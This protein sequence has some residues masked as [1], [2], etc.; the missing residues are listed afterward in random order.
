LIINGASVVFEGTTANDFETTLTVTDP[1]ADRTITFPNSSGTVALSGSISLGTDT[2]GNYV[3]DVSAGT[4]V[5]VSHTP[6]EGSTPTI[7]IGQAV[8]TIANVQFYSVQTTGDITVG[9]NLTVNGT[10]TTLNTSTLQ[11][12]DNVVT[13]NHGAISPINNAGIE[14]NRGMAY[15][16][17]AIRWNEMSDRWEFTNDGTNYTAIGGSIM[18]S[19]TSAAIITMDIGA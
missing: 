15:F 16:V 18:S 12:E 17:P 9:G 19:S 14:V 5:S 11:V 7:S 4:G 3:S 1:T 2:T 10:T 13:L 6:G 8:D